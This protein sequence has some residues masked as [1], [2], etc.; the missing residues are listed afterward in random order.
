MVTTLL[1]RSLSPCVY[2]ISDPNL[3][4]TKFEIWQSGVCFKLHNHMHPN[5]QT[6]YAHKPEST[7]LGSSLTIFCGRDGFV[8]TCFFFV[9]FT[10]ITTRKH[11]YFFQ[12]KFIILSPADNEQ[13]YH[14]M[15]T[16]FAKPTHNPKERVAGTNWE[17]FLEQLVRQSGP[18]TQLKRYINDDYFHLQWHFTP[19]QR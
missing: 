10:V 12:S 11:T 9:L 1:A 13:R 3:P 19:K 8:L 14:E 2:S 5:T 16:S 4:S 18:S 17:A 7:S 6:P 15:R